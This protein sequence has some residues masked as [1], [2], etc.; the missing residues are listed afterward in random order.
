MKL[1]KTCIFISQR[2]QILFLVKELCEWIQEDNQSDDW[3]NEEIMTVVW[4]RKIY[5]N[6]V[7]NEVN[8]NEE[9]MEKEP[10]RI[11]KIIIIGA[12]SGDG[13]WMT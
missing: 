11:S 7:Y 1:S 13:V 9:I 8:E 10:P 4:Q 3:H 2:Y 5:M 12:D 6:E